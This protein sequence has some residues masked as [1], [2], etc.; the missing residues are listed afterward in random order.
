MAFRFTVGTFNYERGGWTPDHTQLDVEPL[1]ETISRAVPQVLYLQEC[2]R[3]R[4]DGQAIL[5][6][7]A[8]RLSEL[9]PG[10]DRYAPFL[11]RRG[12]DANP[13]AILVSQQAVEIDRWHD[14]ID[15][16]MSEWFHNFL[17]ARIASHEVW[18]SS[19]H[20]HGGHGDGAFERQAALLAQMAGHS[21]LVGGDFNCTAS[22]PREV[23][24]DWREIAER[25]PHKLIQ[26]MN[27]DPN[28]EMWVTRT[29]PLDMLLGAWDDQRQQRASWGGFCDVGEHGEFDEH[30]D[31][32]ARLTPTV[33]PK[34]DAGGSI[35]IDRL[36]ASQRFPGVLVPRSYQVHIPPEG[37]RPSDHRY[38]TA[39]FDLPDL[40]MQTGEFSR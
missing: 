29:W 6:T 16:R 34:V 32:V 39:S 31:P 35:R 15:G 11:G 25:Q 23:S 33:N 20:W 28:A 30:G 19:I 37:H 17:K 5:R 4:D 12:S 1:I 38:V 10:G 8:Q 27:Y 24:R 14:P 2:R 18:L 40:P 36:L 9:L 7:V 21:T 3:W 26:K 22:G 13:P